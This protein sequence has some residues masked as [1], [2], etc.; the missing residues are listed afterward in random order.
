MS[1][2]N[3]K[4]HVDRY[5]AYME[6]STA[7][8]WESHD[9]AY[10]AIRSHKRL[11]THPNADHGHEHYKWNPYTLV[12][13]LQ[14]REIGMQNYGEYTRTCA[15]CLEDSLVEN[16]AVGSIL[17]ESFSS[18]AIAV[19]RDGTRL[20]TT[21]GDHAIRIFDTSTAEVVA[22]SSCGTQQCSVQLGI[23]KFY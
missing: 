8:P 20:A 23:I 1:A 2:V 22:V 7:E 18:V 16:G 14:Q 17:E 6:G 5:S 21:H 12:G 3:E 19:S 4:G 11:R 9:G 10:D 15:E 13:S